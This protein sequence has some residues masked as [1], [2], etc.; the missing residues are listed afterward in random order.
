MDG[1]N[2]AAIIIALI[3]LGSSLFAIRKERAKEKETLG[4]EQLK[5]ALQ[6]QQAQL[7]R[8][9]AQIQAKD[10]KIEAQS[11]KIDGLHN[12]VENLTHEVLKCHGEKNELAIRIDQIQAELDRMNHP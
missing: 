7:D 12:Q 3:G 10:A 4:V 9:D 2:I 8:Q 6:T 1:S 11:A 5:L